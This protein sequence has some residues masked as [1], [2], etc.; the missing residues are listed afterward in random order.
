MWKVF[1]CEVIVK[2]EDTEKRNQEVDNYRNVVQLTMSVKRDSEEVISKLWAYYL[3]KNI[4]TMK[5]WYP[6]TL[7]QIQFQGIIYWDWNVNTP[8]LKMEDFKT[9]H[10]FKNEDILCF[11]GE[12]NLTFYTRI[13]KHKRKDV[14]HLP[15]YTVL[16]YLVMI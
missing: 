7:P 11:N 4:I 12:E 15:K 13:L 14:Y 1:I 5:W 6:V 10:I 2:T 16:N 8:L 9:L 3:V